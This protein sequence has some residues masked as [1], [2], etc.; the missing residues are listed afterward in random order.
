MKYHHVFAVVSIV[1]TATPALADDPYAVTP[2]GRAEAVFDVPA[3]QTSDLLAGACMNA[4]WVIKDQNPSQVVCEAPATFGQS[5]M[6]NL[7]MGNNY[8]TP[9]RL[10]YRFSIAE[11]TNESRV[12]ANGWMGLQTAFG[13]N[14]EMDTNVDGFH[15]NAMDMMIFAAG[16]RYPVGTEF[17]NHVTIGSGFRIVEE[18]RQGFLLS[19]VDENGPFYRAGIR[20]GDLVTRIAGDRWKTWNDFYDGLHKA[21]KKPSYEVEFYRDGKKMELMVEREYRSAVGAPAVSNKPFHQAHGR[22]SGIIGS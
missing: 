11:M 22:P 15:N 7:L 5:L 9:P 8:S 6:A 1:A 18:P 20:D 16:G 14:R 19:N 2:N 3:Q 17:P 13:Q 4:N 12:Q 21:A 10:Y